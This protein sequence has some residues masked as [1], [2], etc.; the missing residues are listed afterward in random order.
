M[1][2]IKQKRKSTPTGTRLAKLGIV[3]AAAAAFFLL[4]FAVFC[5]CVHMAAPPL[6]PARFAALSQ[7]LVVYDKDGVPAAC[8]DDGQ[9]R[10]LIDASILPQNVKYAF[11]AAEDV[12][13]YSHRGIDIRRMF[14]ALLQNVKSG[15]YAQGASTITQQ[16]VKLTHLTSEKTITRKLFEIDLALQV[17]RRYSKDE[18]LSMYLNTVYFGGGY[19]GIEAAAQ[20]YFHCSAAELTTAQAAALA[21]VLSSPDAYA[22]HLHP[23]ACA[24]RR[25][26]ILDIM[27]QHD[28]IDAQEAVRAKNTPLSV[29]EQDGRSGH[30]WLIDRALYESCEILGIDLCDLYGGGYRIFTTLDPELQAACEAIFSDESLYPRAP[31]GELAQCAAVVLDQNGGV[32]A[33]VGGRNY[34]SALCFNRATD[35]RRQSGSVIK[36]ICVYAPAIEEN[37]A[38]AMDVV[39]DEP[40]DF[41]SYEPHNYGGTY[42]GKILLC[43]ALAQSVNIPAVKLLSELGP[44]TGLAYAKRA[45]LPLTQQDQSL[46]LALGGLTQ[47]VTPLEMAG[48]YGALCA[49][50]THHEPHFVARIETADGETLYEVSPKTQFFVSEQSA[51]T[52]SEMLRYTVQTGTAAALQNAGVPL[53]AKTGTVDYEGLGNRDIWAAAYNDRY[54]AIVWMGMD[55]T[56]AESYLPASATGGRNST[57]ALCRIFRALYPD[58]GDD[59]FAVP[60]GMEEVSFER[61]GTLNA[62]TPVLSGSYTPKD[63]R[64]T[65]FVTPEN[66]AANKSR[67]WRPA[68]PPQDLTVQLD[69]QNVPTVTF[70]MGDNRCY[71]ELWRKSANGRE[72]QLA[73][74]DGAEPGTVFRDVLAPVGTALSYRVRAVHKQSGVGGAFGESVRAIRPL[75]SLIFTLP[76]TNKAN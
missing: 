10:T 36:P 55:E 75:Q 39:V 8:F 37:G 59:W 74:F 61:A 41:G 11:V 52:L 6:S 72:T 22:P 48:A 46:A 2:A 45:G 13:F 69:T 29:A 30:G 51:Y 5:L 35:A 62:G 4:S 17:E 54:C 7:T 38:F 47:G 53:A 60:D 1:K 73:T 70:S 44:Q 66:A 26:L 31:N 76:R 57:E 58:G 24:A 3:F 23:D 21:A 43:D 49:K 68:D 28:F 56:N 9:D 15:S 18:I 40:T 42:S 64:M 25:D 14:G 33:I 32:C 50:G 63:D 12:R 20:G 67:Y 16:L 34:E 27:A 65:L 71:F 19:Y